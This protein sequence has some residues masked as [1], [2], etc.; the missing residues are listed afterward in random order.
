MAAVT[1]TRASCQA[2][3]TVF[4]DTAP[5][6]TASLDPVINDDDSDSDS[7][8]DSDGGGRFVASFS[9]T[10]GCDSSPSCGAVLTVPGCS[11]IAIEDGQ[12]IDFKPRS[13]CR[14]KEKN[15]RLEVKGPSLTLD[16]S[17]TDASGNTGTASAEPPPPPPDDDDDSDSDSDG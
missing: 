12:V 11:P 9:A 13:T 10:D 14:V 4:D 8:S 15:G 7:D 1:P 5:A 2:T 17:C 16:V 6:A 3:V